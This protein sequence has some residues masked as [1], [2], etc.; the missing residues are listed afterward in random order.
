ME[1][2]WEVVEGRGEFG[3]TS[4]MRIT[5]PNGWLYRERACAG[6][7]GVP[8]AIAL[9]FVPLAIDVNINEV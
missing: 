8:T 5:Q 6:R 9:V 1:A 3:D 2:K 4:R 7:D